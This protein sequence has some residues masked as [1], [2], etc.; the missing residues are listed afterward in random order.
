MASRFG[1]DHHAHA[2]AVALV[3][4][5]GDALDGLLAHQLGDALDHAGLVDLVG[6]L[7]DDDRLAVLADLLDRVRPAS[8]RE[9]R[10]V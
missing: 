2:V 4:Q 9:P 1:L 10:P 5:V 3:A 6:H 7:G 8:P